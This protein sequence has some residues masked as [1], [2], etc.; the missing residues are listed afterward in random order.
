[1]DK[2]K[3][4]FPDSIV[5]DFQQI[6]MISLQIIN[7]LIVTPDAAKRITSDQNQSYLKNNRKSIV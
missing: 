5:H 1:M 7:T 6:L 3:G 4:R 2:F